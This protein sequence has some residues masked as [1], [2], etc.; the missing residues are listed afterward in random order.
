MKN[1]TSV[2]INIRYKTILIKTRKTYKI[3]IYFV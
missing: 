2:K 3:I 1:N